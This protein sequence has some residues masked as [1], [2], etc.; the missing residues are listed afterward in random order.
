ME[1]K[2]IKAKEI[3]VTKIHRGRTGKRIHTQ[4]QNSSGF[5]HPNKR[6]EFEKEI[7]RW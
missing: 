1:R 3:E 4:P 6:K 5:R 7:T 2:K